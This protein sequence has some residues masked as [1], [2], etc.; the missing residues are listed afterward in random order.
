MKGQGQGGHLLARDYSLGDGDN[1]TEQHLKGSSFENR[2]KRC[3]ALS[4][5]ESDIIA[6]D[7]FQTLD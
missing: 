7:C 2:R 1:P 3:L 5:G 4:W 6:S